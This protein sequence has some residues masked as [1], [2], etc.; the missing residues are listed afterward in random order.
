[1]DLIVDQTGQEVLP[2]QVHDFGLR[3]G[4]IPVH[5]PNVRSFNQQIGFYYPPFVYQAGVFKQSAF[6]LKIRSF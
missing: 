3:V 6:H 1:M 2:L 4:N 5:A